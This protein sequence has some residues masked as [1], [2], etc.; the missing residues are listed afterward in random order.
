MIEIDTPSRGVVV[1]TMHRPDSRNA[2]DLDAFRALARQWRA[3]DAD[4][5]CRAVVV[6]GGGVDF[7][8]GADLR[9][10]G[11]QLNAAAA[12]GEPARDLWAEINLAVLRDAGLTVPTISA[13]R[14]ICFGAGMELVGGTDIRIAA[15]DARFALPEVRRGVIASGGSV[16]RLPRQIPYAMAMD[17]LLTGREVTAVELLAAG[18]LTQV[19]DDQAVLPTAIARAR[20][21]ADNSPA[22]VR[23]VKSAVNVGLRGDL[24]AAFDIEARVAREVLAGPEAAEGVRAFTERRRPEWQE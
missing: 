2:F 19:V 6:T 16:A 3:L 1:V 11:P 10:L 17:V 22:A 8:S 20:A 4:P 9:S 5:S 13:V 18:F 15:A 7:S 23:A 24:A 21:I 14:G 12:A